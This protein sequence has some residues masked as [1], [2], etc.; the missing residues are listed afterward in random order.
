M[1]RCGVAPSNNFERLKLP[2]QIIYRREKNLSES[3]NHFKISGKYFDFATL[4]VIF[5]K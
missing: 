1:R 3:P 5:A 4:R 2:Q